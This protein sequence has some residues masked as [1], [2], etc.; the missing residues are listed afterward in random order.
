LLQQNFVQ[1][2]KQVHKGHDRLLAGDL[3]HK[4]HFGIN[5]FAAPVMYEASEFVERNVHRLPSELLGAISKSSNS[6]IAGFFKSVIVQAGDQT[7]G[8]KR[9]VKRSP[10]KAVLEKFR[11]DLH[12][13]MKS[14]EDTETR[15]IR[16]VK[17]N[18]TLSPAK[19]DHGTVMRQLR[20]AGLV[21]AIDLS[22]ETYPNKLP[23]SVVEDRFGC[24][25]SPV[26]AVILH[27]MPVYDRVQYIMSRLYAPL[28]EVYRNCEFTMPYACGKTKAF[29]RS[30]ALEMLESLRL[31]FFSAWTLVIQ[32]DTRRWLAQ[33][34]VL[35]LR[36]GVKSLQ[37]Q[38]RGFSSR[39]MFRRTRG[40]VIAI[41]SFYRSQKERKRMEVKRRAIV[42]LQS[43]W[44]I[45][46]DTNLKLSMLAA[47]SILTAALQM[48][49]E[50]AKFLRKRHLCTQLQGVVRGRSQ[51]EKYR[52]ILEAIS[53]IQATTRRTLLQERAKEQ[54]KAARVIRTFLGNAVKSLRIKRAVGRIQVFG[55]R[56]IAV[57]T[58]R[59]QRR[60]IVVIRS[61]LRTAI[62]R[63]RF[64]N[65]YMAT[66]TLQSFFRMR[67]ERIRYQM[68]LQSY[69]HRSDASDSSE[70]YTT[71]TPVSRDGPASGIL[72][73]W[74]NEGLE[75]QKSVLSTKDDTGKPGKTYG[76]NSFSFSVSAQSGPSVKAGP[77]TSSSSATVSDHEDE[78][79]FT[80]LH[81]MT[82]DST[83]DQIIAKLKQEIDEMRYQ[84]TQMRED[85]AAVVEEAKGH[86]QM[87]EE[88]FEDRIVAYEEEVV[89]LKEIIKESQA[90][91]DA[92]YGK[93]ELLRHADHVP[94]HR[95][96][97]IAMEQQAKSIQASHVEYISNISRVLD[98]AN[99]ARRRETDRILGEFDSL[100][101]EKD[102]EM[103]DLRAQIR[104]TS[105]AGI[106]STQGGAPVSAD[107][108]QAS[109]VSELRDAILA[110]VSP[111]R[112]AQI[113][114]R[115]DRKPWSKEAYVDEKL[116]LRVGQY[117]ERL[118]EI[119]VSSL[120]S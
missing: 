92:L 42:V 69:Q 81:E 104:L 17:P 33:R 6:I 116:S 112:V 66:L 40:A 72:R 83:K 25:M 102:Q 49:V 13:L 115:A 38:A 79:T 48:R 87:V 88:E 111:A 75:E 16:C 65:I 9:Q 15:Y 4:S 11:L 35:R 106:K 10:K 96:K 89:Q 93:V 103:K 1:K 109:E 84:E 97:L 26:D 32:T 56:I 51:R 43:R 64:I 91:K 100:K 29:F 31:Q 41:Q 8:V 34:K 46:R 68:R 86:E 95:E 23:L 108:D 3:L 99:E 54:R 44:R 110:A 18:E 22:R 24:L 57:E 118:C 78:P 85:I 120:P 5:H 76:C 117:V 7:T 50:R 55:R 98:A 59:Q 14:M 80:A 21:T 101:L 70:I 28:L 82:V 39:K 12:D 114:G 94:D 60:T 74:M 119:A 52:A 58:V 107:S 105:N 113:V 71:A 37:A 90:E 73:K 67:I 47:T 36:N 30:G 19:F 61:F 63:M 27:E 20:C 45:V 62:Q 53:S 77:E 2:L